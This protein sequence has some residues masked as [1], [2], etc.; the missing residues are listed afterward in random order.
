M[1]LRLLLT[2]ALAR[3]ARD[4][5]S[6][7]ECAPAGSIDRRTIDIAAGT[8]CVRSPCPTGATYA[9]LGA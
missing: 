3:A 7:R 4:D 9:A 8:R 1:Q 2:G 5:G 6:Q